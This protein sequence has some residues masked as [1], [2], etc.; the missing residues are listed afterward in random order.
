MVEKR[1][2]R[3]GS[4]RPARV[5][6]LALAVALAACAPA[7]HGVTDSIE[8]ASGAAAEASLAVYPLGP[9][10][11]LKITVFG[12]AELSGEFDIDV[13]GSIAYPLL[14]DVPASD[15][16]LRQLGREVAAALDRDFVV[17]PRV[18]VEVVRFRPFFILGQVNRPG[19]YPY[20]VGLNVRQAVAIAG[21][22]TRRARETG[23]V[24]VRRTV[25]GETLRRVPQ[26]APILPG[27]TLEV[28]RRLF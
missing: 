27:D 22:F 20:V 7:D 5:G 9:G 6:V 13:N 19:S 1:Q 11:R 21:G 26:G 14:G 25:D 3:H 12:Q 18:I 10:D 15:R 16:S 8:I 23:I 2:R 4:F 24:L 17:D 28:R